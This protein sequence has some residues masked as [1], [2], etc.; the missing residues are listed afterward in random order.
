VDPF[1]TRSQSNKN[2]QKEE[3]VFW[4]KKTVVLGKALIEKFFLLPDPQKATIAF[5]LG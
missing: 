1:T 2:P 3:A 5:G 4:S